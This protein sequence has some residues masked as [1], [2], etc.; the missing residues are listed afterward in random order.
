MRRLLLAIALTTMSGVPLQAQSFSTRPVRFVVPAAPGG[1]FDTLVRIIAQSLSDRWAD[2]P[3]I[4]E[5]GVPDYQA[6]AFHGFLAPAGTPTAS[7]T[8]LERDITDVLKT[9]EVRRKLI[10]LGFDPVAGSAADFAA[11]IDRDV[12]REVVRTSSIKA[13]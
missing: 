6:N 9:P 3:T 1:S 2:V 5:A 8:K 13:E 4:A 12:W 7:V 10:D 11:I